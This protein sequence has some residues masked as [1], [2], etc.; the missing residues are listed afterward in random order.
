MRKRY[1][2]ETMEALHGTM[3]SLRS[4]GAIDAKRL[5]EFDETC[6]VPVFQIYKD[7]RE[8]WRWRLVS[9]GGKII[10]TSGESYKSKKL[11]VA[12]IEIVKSAAHAEIAA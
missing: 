9:G 12:A 4:V 1:K 6:L 7:R 2:S 11:C 5:R 8:E 10:A 3:Q